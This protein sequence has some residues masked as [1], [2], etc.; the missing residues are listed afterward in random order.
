MDTI[1]NGKKFFSKKIN[2]ISYFIDSSNLNSFVLISLPATIEKKPFNLQLFFDLSKE[3]IDLNSNFGK[4]VFFSN[5]L[6]FEDFLKTND[7]FYVT[8]LLGKKK[9]FI[10][11]SSTENS[12]ICQ[13]TGEHLIVGSSLLLFINKDGTKVTYKKNT[14]LVEKLSSNSHGFYEYKTDKNI[15][16]KYSNDN[17]SVEFVSNSSD[18]RITRIDIKQNTDSNSLLNYQ[19]FLTYNSDNYL[20]QI[21]YKEN[22]VTIEKYAFTKGESVFIL[23]DEIYNQS[24]IE[25]NYGTHKKIETY[26]NSVFIGAQTISVSGNKTTITNKEGKKIQYLYNEKHQ[27]EYEVDE[28]GW[29]IRHYYDEWNREIETS[30]TLQ[31]FSHITQ[32]E[33][34]INNGN[35][36]TGLDSYLFNGSSQVLDNITP[37]TPT[38]FDGKYQGKWVKIEALYPDMNCYIKKTIVKK[39][40]KGDAFTATL[41]GYTSELSNNKN[42]D[43]CIFFLNDS[44]ESLGGNITSESLVVDKLSI[45]TNSVEA[46]AEFSKIEVEVRIRYGQKFFIKELGLYEISVGQRITYGYHGAIRKIQR[47]NEGVRTTEDQNGRLL[48]LTSSNFS[49]DFV[50]EYNDMNQPVKSVDIFHNATEMEYDEDGELICQRVQCNNVYSVSRRAISYSY[51]TSTT[52]TTTEIDT[53]GQTSVEVIEINSNSLQSYL[54][55]LSKK[56]EYGYNAYHDLIRVKESKNGTTLREQNITYDENHRVQKVVSGNGSQIRFEYNSYGLP[57]YVYADDD[58]T[59]LENYVYENDETLRAKTG[60][61]TQKIYGDDELIEEYEYNEDGQLKTISSQKSDETSSVRDYRFVYDKKSRL[62]HVYSINE[63]LRAYYYT[64]EDDISKIQITQGETIDIVRKENKEGYVVSRMTPNGEHSF[65][66]QSQF[67]EATRRSPNA[68]LNGVFQEFYSNFFTEEDKETGEFYT[69]LKKENDDGSMTFLPNKYG[70]KIAIYHDKKIPYVLANSNS[71]YFLRYDFEQKS[72]MLW[73]GCLFHTLSD[74][75]PDTDKTIIGIKVSNQRSITI[76]RE[77]NKIFINRSAIGNEISYISPKVPFL[78]NE[79]NYIGVRIYINNEKHCTEYQFFV[80][81]KSYSLL[82]DVEIAFDENVSAYYCPNMK[83]IQNKSRALGKYSCLTIQ[84]EDIEISAIE[85]YIYSVFHHLIDVEKEGSTWKQEAIQTKHTL[86]G[87][88]ESS[89]LSNW[90]YFPLNGSITSVKG[91][92]DVTLNPKEEYYKA[93]NNY[94][95][96]DETLR[97][98]VFDLTRCTLSKTIDFPFE[99]GKINILFDFKILESETTDDF[100]ILTTDGLKIFVEK[101]E[102]NSAQYYVCYIFGSSNKITTSIKIAKGAWN[103]FQLGLSREYGMIRMYLI[104]NGSRFV[105]YQS[106]SLYSKL[107]ITIAE[108]AN[109]LLANFLYGEGEYSKYESLLKRIRET[110][111]TD[112][113]G[114]VLSSEIEDNGSVVI[115]KSYSYENRVVTED[116]QT[117]TRTSGIISEEIDT[118]GGKQTTTSYVFDELGRILSKKLGATITSHTFQYD[119]RGFLSEEK[120]PTSLQ[121]YVYDYDNNGNIKTI[122]YYKNSSTVTPT[123]TAFTYGMLYKDRLEKVGNDVLEYEE[124]NPLYVKRI[125]NSSTQEDKMNF[126]WRG[127]R[128]TKLIVDGNT[129]IEYAYNEDGTRRKKTISKIENGT[130]TTLDQIFYSYVDGQ[131]QSETHSKGYQLQYFYGLDGRLLFFI[132]RK[133]NIETRYYYRWDLLG[134]TGI[135]D[136]DGNEVANYNYDAYGNMQIIHLDDS[137]GAINPMRYKGYYYDNETAMYCIMNRYFHPNYR[138]FITPDSFGNLDLKS[139]NGINYYCYSAINLQK[140]NFGLSKV[141]SFNDEIYN[142]NSHTNIN[143]EKDFSVPWIVENGTSI[144]GYSML[145]KNNAELIKFCF[146]QSS[147]ITSDITINSSGPFTY[148]KELSKSLYSKKLSAIDCFLIFIDLSLDIYVN[149]K[150]K[151]NVPQILISALLTVTCDIVLLLLQP[152]IVQFFVGICFALIGPTIGLAVAILLIILF[153]GLIAF[154]L[155]KAKDRII[156]SLN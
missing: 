54:D 107:N 63:L 1:N 7:C 21:E 136:K 85:Q 51:G 9:K 31:I 67:D 90:D 156:K 102:T 124:S 18:K 137:I 119:A 27:L 141:K 39:G 10:P 16:F 95:S 155:G 35:F 25:T 150:N 46:P 129:E 58:N 93:N 66:Y 73:V 52:K 94:Y 92:R 28:K 22:G 72:S 138:R 57:E 80:N 115:K 70:E 118:Y 49:S 29:V 20:S 96:Y 87:I 101:D 79:W 122:K 65:E 30:R 19:I 3:E 81:K 23:K 83:E 105:N 139:I 153:S 154:L 149:I 113:L 121:R 123:I 5:K 60:R 53:R 82:D 61:I 144:Y 114:R 50:E 127:S 106:N 69:K 47:G 48:S 140:F 13:S 130:S 125:Y 42:V 116:G 40:H 151:R 37:I 62:T 103:K 131:L 97:Q 117:E 33:N 43:L 89:G 14:G 6:F 86:L 91:N 78:E 143:K 147:F 32:N 88:K 44:G 77:G 134:I 126:T 132:Y 15:V 59:P 104:I 2:S 38:F 56:E 76:E 84:N 152:F 24:I 99:T 64:P 133:D 145:I 120:L 146:I 41:L 108:N 142:Y 109:C 45:C 75:S 110:T 74:D 12:L 55:P 17:C 148:G 128:L 4:G 34:L 8:N 68:I 26:V 135:I 98:E 112:R 36:S 111:E 100:K 71:G 11:D